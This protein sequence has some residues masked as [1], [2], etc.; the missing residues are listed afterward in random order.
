MRS[1]GVKDLAKWEVEQ[2]RAEMRRK[3]KE[4]LSEVLLTVDG[5]KKKTEEQLQAEREEVE[6]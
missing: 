6:R 5:I 2:L 1:S 3:R 4:R